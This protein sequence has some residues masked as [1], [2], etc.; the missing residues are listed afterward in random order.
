[1]LHPYLEATVSLLHNAP[2]LGPYY[3]SGEGPLNAVAQQLVLMGS[4]LHHKKM[5]NVVYENGLGNQYNNKGNEIMDIQME[6]D[7]NIHPIENVTN[8][9]IYID[10]KPSEKEA[11]ER[12][13]LFAE[14]PQKDDKRGSYKHYRDVEKD[15]LFFLAEEKGMS[16]RTAALKLNINVRTAQGQV[17]KNNKDLQK[18]I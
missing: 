14:K 8:F 12:E 18:Y 16:V 3:A 6:V 4:K 7:N 5:N 13:N 10:S 2:G 9:D 17:S 11:R 15:Q 1:M